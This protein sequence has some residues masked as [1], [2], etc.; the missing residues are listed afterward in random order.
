MKLRRGR[1][2]HRGSASDAVL[3]VVLVVGGATALTVAGVY[4]QNDG[5]GMEAAVAWGGFC[6]LLAAVSFVSALRMP[7]RDPLRLPLWIAALLAVGW[8]VR[9]FD[10]ELDHPVLSAVREPLSWATLALLV[11]ALVHLVARRV[12]RRRIIRAA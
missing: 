11:A 8:S 5:L 10:A 9:A 2:H 7:R 3:A 4:V 1:G 12:R 6:A